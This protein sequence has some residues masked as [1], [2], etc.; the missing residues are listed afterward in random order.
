M[1][2]TLQKYIDLPANRAG[3]GFDHA[4]I[5]AASKRL[6]VAHTANDAVDIIDCREDRYLESIDG[7]GG[8]AGVLVSEERGLVFTSN[9]GEDT[10]SVF[11]PGAEGLRFKIKV[12]MRPNGLAFDPARGILLAANVGDAAIAGSRTV[13]IVDLTRRVRSAEIAVP[14]PTRWAMYDPLHQLFYV[15]IGSPAL[16]IAISA[17]ESP[18]IVRE[19]AV[20]ALGPHGLALDAGNNRLL[21]ACDAALLVAIDAT[22]GQVVA[23]VGLS[24]K[25]DVVMQDPLTSRLYV[26]IGDPGVIDVIDTVAL[27]RIESVATEAGAHTLAFDPRQKKLYAFLPSSHRAMVLRDQA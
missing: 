21:C 14:G 5:H 6:Y 20:P 26:A 16:I 22:T 9:R 2:L 23:E 24:G 7:L 4:D 15:N 10:V 18:S 12:G 25:P 11:A 17:E 1:P 8:V 3:G 27:S 19:F 13:S